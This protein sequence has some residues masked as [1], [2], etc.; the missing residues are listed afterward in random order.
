MCIVFLMIRRPPRSTRTDTLFPYTTLFRS[1]GGRQLVDGR[2]RRLAHRL[3]I[4]T[5]GAG[6]QLPIQ[7]ASMSTRTDTAG[8][9][10]TIEDRG[11][12]IRVFEQ[13][14]KPLEQWRIGTEPEKFVYPPHE[15][16]KNGVEGKSGAERGDQG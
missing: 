4:V 16:R 15:P 5:A 3:N 11:Q 14:R 6:S 1:G 2:Q 7:A 8:E 13:G 12:L 10:P 9:D